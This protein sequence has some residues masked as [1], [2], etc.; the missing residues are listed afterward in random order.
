MSRSESR[1]GVILQ[2]T[3]ATVIYQDHRPDVWIYSIAHTIGV[4]SLSLGTMICL[5]GGTLEGGGQ[6]VR[7]A[8]AL[9]ALTGQP[10]RITRIRGNRPGA[11]GLRSSHAAAI[12]CL[13]DICGGTAVNATVRSSEITFYPRGQQ[14]GIEPAAAKEKDFAAALRTIKLEALAGVP[15]IQPRYNVRLKTPGSAFLIFQA[16]YPYLLY[17][18]ACANARAAEHGECPPEATIKLSVTGGTNVSF[19][20][21]YDYVSQVLCP[22]FAR[23]GLPHLDVELKHRGWSAGATD[24]G[25]VSFLIHPLD[26]QKAAHAAGLAADDPRCSSTSFAPVFPAININRYERGTITQIDITVLAPDT[27]LDDIESARKRR[28]FKRHKSKDGRTE[29]YPDAG[30]AADESDSGPGKRSAP[31]SVR[32]FIENYAFQAVCNAFTI[33]SKGGHNS[34]QPKIQLHHSERTRHYSQTYILLVAHTSTG[35]RLGRDALFGVSNTSE[36]KI[37][38][39]NKP[40]G[41]GKGQGRSHAKSRVNTGADMERAIEGMVNRCV[42]DLMY[43]LADGDGARDVKTMLGDDQPSRLLDSYMRDQIV[44]FQALG[45]LAAGEEN[46]PSST[47]PE[48]GLSL[49]TQTAMWSRPGGLLGGYSTMGSLNV[50]ILTFNC[51]RNLIDTNRFASHLFDGLHPGAPQTAAHLPDLLVLALQEVAPIAYAFLGGSYLDRYYDAFRD[52]LD[53]ATAGAAGD[54]AGGHVHYRNLVT[55]NIG[56]TALMV[57]ARSDVVER[58]RYIQ[59]AETGVGVHEAGNKGAVG[60][61]IGCLAGREDD[62]SDAGHDGTVEVTVVSAHLA[63]DETGWQRR[64]QDWKSIAQRLV[65][66]SEGTEHPLHQEDEE[67]MP[68]LRSSASLNEPSALYSPNSYLF[69]AG[70]FNYRTADARPAPQDYRTFPRPLE[71]E[72]PMSQFTDLFALDQLNREREAGRVFNRLMEPKVMF[73]P[74]YK[75]SNDARSLASVDPNGGWK[76]AKTRWPSWCDR[77]LYLDHPSKTNESGIVK[78][79]RYDILPLCSTSDHRPVVLSASVPLQALPESSDYRPPFEVDPHWEDKRA[80]ARRKELVVGAVAY[81]GLTWEGNGIVVATVFGLAA[82]YYGLHALLAG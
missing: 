49:H 8:V 18:G 7:N 53:I 77:I 69:V 51:A 76:W 55:K 81:L 14:D 79:H 40:K 48:R 26:I 3:M 15:P 24:L 43:E 56:M 71:N 31:H 65:F 9:S 6:L 2:Q 70:D 68:L 52:A 57:F 23:L 82:A 4:G 28:S 21:S 25:A 42:E 63:P 44:V 36:S 75:Y 60:A 30:L 39:G 45:N 67:G 34:Q 22:N 46:M 66:R 61:R 29:Q 58:I 11:T 64:N 62:S 10:V 37:K 35:F 41:Q 12:Q 80:V 73:P 54:G 20:P 5:D 33:K 38:P 72:D 1:W 50:Y 47:P 16:L 59:T 17:A 19:S 74:T 78:I 13:L 32:E 27:T